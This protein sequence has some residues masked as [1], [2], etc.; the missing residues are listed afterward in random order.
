VTAPLTHPAA[1]Q[2]HASASSGLTAADLGRELA[3]RGIPGVVG[4]ATRGAIARVAVNADGALMV[5][6]AAGRLCAT[7]P[8]PVVT[9]LAAAWRADVLLEGEGVFVSASARADAGEEDHVSALGDATRLYVVGGMVPI[10]PAKRLELATQLESPISVLPAADVHLVVP[11]GVATDYWPP[12]QRPVVAVTADGDAVRIEVY[13]RAGLAGGGVRERLAMR[14]IPDLTLSWEARWR[15]VLPEVSED[16]AHVQRMLRPARLTPSALAGAGYDPAGAWAELGTD[17]AAVGALI[18]HE[19]DEDLF[20]A[21]VATLGLPIVTTSLIR[22][23]V[24]VDDLPGA[25]H[26]ERT[27]LA[28]M[29]REQALAPPR[30]S[31][32]WARYRRPTLAHPGLA[33]LLIG[34]EAAATAALI[35]VLIVAP[36]GPPWGTVLWI[37]ASVLVLDVAADL[38]FLRGQR[39]RNDEGPADRGRT[40]PS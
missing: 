6:D 28:R 26:I 4:D 33:A 15:A 12:A 19:N 38:V 20:D 39:G 10:D 7:D 32:P 25:Q 24:A 30:G 16:V 23:V 14:G 27:S 1:L 11:H 35:T 40:G 2:I 37:V 29:V 21:I 9:A 22:G 8:H 13:S 18:A 3:A 17:P 5:M 31:S 36:P 34:L